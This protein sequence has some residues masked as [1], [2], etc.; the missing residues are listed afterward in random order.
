MDLCDLADFNNYG[1]LSVTATATVAAEITAASRQ[2]ELFCGGVGCLSWQ[3]GRVDT[4]DGSGG[5]HLWLPVAPVDT[6]TT[7]V[8][9][10]TTLTAGS[11]FVVYEATGKLTR[12]WSEYRE[13]R[14]TT[15]RKAVVVTYDAGYELGGATGPDVPED[16]RRV[17]A[18]L[19]VRR[20]KAEATAA[21]TP[22]G[23]VG[24]LTGVTLDG[25]GTQQFAGAANTSQAA[26]ATQAQQGSGP[27]LTS[28][29][30]R[31]LSPYRR[32]RFG[33]AANPQTVF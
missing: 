8:E 7:V 10:G 23:A 31:A 15:K 16:L 21:A 18:N 6:I 27:A 20:Y 17:V 30:K 19:A 1:Q 32:V 24:P 13:Y 25:V 2:V 5:P 33:G 29:E 11:Q 14:W 22:A 26:E 28:S 3:A 12:L 4:L 9:D